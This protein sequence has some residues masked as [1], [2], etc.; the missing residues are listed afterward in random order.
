MYLE[1]GPLYLEGGPLYLEG[2]LL[3]LDAITSVKCTVLVSM[4]SHLDNSLSHVQFSLSEEVLANDHVQ[5]LG[6]F[7]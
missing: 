1:G 7:S 3:Y 4:T 6:T 2:G 5:L